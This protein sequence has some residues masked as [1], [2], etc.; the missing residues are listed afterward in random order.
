LVPEAKE[1]LEK[2]KIESENE[3]GI[4]INEK[5]KGNISSRTNG[6]TGGPMVV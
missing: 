6:H 1:K 4:A 3:I 5:Y 2:L